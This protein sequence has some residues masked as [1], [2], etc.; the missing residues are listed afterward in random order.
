MKKIFFIITFV[1]SC[2]TFSFAQN[3]Q[4]KFP[5]KKTDY[6]SVKKKEVDSFWTQQY[7]KD[8]INFDEFSGKIIKA[9]EEKFKSYIANA[10]STMEKNFKNLSNNKNTLSKSDYMNTIM[11]AEESIFDQEDTNKDGIISEEEHKTFLA[12]QK[13]S[14]AASPAPKK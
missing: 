7:G 3:N 10:K 9:E 12:K 6:L 5:L 2:A 11:K 14:Q 1:T 4:I 8:E 13:K